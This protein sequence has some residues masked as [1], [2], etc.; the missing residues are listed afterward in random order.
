[1]LY[2]EILM[3]KY[4]MR[5]AYSAKFAPVKIASR[6]MIILGFNFSIEYPII[7]ICSLSLSERGFGREP[8]QSSKSANR[9]FQRSHQ[10]SS[11]H[12]RRGRSI[13]RPQIRPDELLQVDG[14]ILGID[15]SVSCARRHS[16]EDVSGRNFLPPRRGCDR[17]K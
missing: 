7:R 12:H 2:D 14:A 15:C 4:V 9:V 8:A 3:I 5:F 10:A 13:E 1:M 6:R 11:R 16:D 17:F